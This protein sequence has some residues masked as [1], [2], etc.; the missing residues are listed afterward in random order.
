MERRLEGSQVS[1]PTLQQGPAP[2]VRVLPS[3]EIE[4]AQVDSDAKRKDTP[5]DYSWK[6]LS[7]QTKQNSIILEPK[8]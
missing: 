4:A 1:P 3:L 2:S 5:N 8:V 7:K 6:L